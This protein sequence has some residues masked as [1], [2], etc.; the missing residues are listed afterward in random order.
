MNKKRKTM[1]LIIVQF[2]C[3]V[4]FVHTLGCA[5]QGYEILNQKKV[6]VQAGKNTKVTLFGVDPTAPHRA[7]VLCKTVGEVLTWSL[8][9]KSFPY[10]SFRRAA[11][12]IG[13][14]GVT[15]IRSS[16]KKKNRYYRRG[17]VVLCP[18]LPPQN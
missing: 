3:A 18:V 9:E 10:T 12:K 6:R 16:G 2:L 15:G 4:F 13:G 17:I 8:G 7:P 1:L 11:R 14:N 5:T